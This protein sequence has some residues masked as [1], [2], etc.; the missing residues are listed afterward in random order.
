MRPDH[1]V[2]WLGQQPD[3][4]VV[5]FHLVQPEINTAV[6]WRHG[7]IRSINSWLLLHYRLQ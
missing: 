1:A 2:G 7:R 3:I 4:D 5:M 6:A